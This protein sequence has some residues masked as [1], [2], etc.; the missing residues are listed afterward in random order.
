VARYGIGEFEH[1][2]AP[3]RASSPAIGNSRRRIPG[4]GVVLATTLGAVNRL[5]LALSAAALVAGSAV[6]TWSVAA[7]YFLHMP[8]EWQDEVSVFLI[9]G[10]VFMSGAAV[11]ARRG[12]IG[13][14]AIATLLSPRA[15]RIRQTIIDLASLAFCAFF[16]WKSWSLLAEAISENFHSGSTWGP[17]LWIPY[18]LMSAGMTLLS[19]QLLLQVLDPLRPQ[20]R[21]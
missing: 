9:V 20:G 2:I 18:S 1:E 11:Q 10:A 14:E 17:P 7:R 21:H 3:D 15:N 16:A 6:L 19:L 8:N 13:I 4:P 12:H 5:I